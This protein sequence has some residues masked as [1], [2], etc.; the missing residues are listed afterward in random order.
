L[1]E[2]VQIRIGILN[3]LTNASLTD[4]IN[5]FAEAMQVMGVKFDKASIMADVAKKLS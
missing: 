4:I 3:Q 1:S 5:R 2:P